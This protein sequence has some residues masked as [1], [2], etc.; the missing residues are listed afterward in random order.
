MHFVCLQLFHHKT[1][2]KPIIFLVLTEKRNFYKY[3]HFYIIYLT[4]QKLQITDMTTNGEMKQTQWKFESL[5]ITAKTIQFEHVTSYAFTRR[6]WEN[7]QLDLQIVLLVFLGHQNQ[8][9][10]FYASVPERMLCLS[11]QLFLRL[12]SSRPVF[13]LLGMYKSDNSTQLMGWK[14]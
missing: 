7:R 8:A 13:M 11:K 2:V 14:T 9:G 10:T 4:I 5:K 3:K 12:A 1:A 6:W